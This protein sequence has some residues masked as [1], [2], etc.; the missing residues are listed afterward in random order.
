MA[1]QQP[2]SSP[3]DRLDVIEV[4]VGLARSFDRKE[5]EDCRRHLMD[6]IDTDYSD[7]RGEPASRVKAEDFVSK[8]R[9]ALA[10]LETLHLSTNH[11]VT[12]DG[13][14]ATCISAAVIHRR[15][16][17]DGERFDTYCTYVHTLTRTAA[18]W[19]IAGI[20][21]IIHWNTGNPDIHEGARRR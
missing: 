2:P 1:G 7:L 20:K 9:A 8:R 12:V 5:W 19:K 16:P 15:R 21:Q 4:I 17:G 11:A 13:D 3:Q 18:G 6:E 10:P 14:S